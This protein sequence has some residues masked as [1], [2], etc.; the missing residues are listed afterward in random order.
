MVTLGCSNIAAPEDERTPELFTPH[1]L[2]D[3]LLR[4]DATNPT[5]RA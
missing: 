4:T 5:R 2:L 3:D 1:H